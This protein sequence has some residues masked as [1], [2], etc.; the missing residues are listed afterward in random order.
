MSDLRRAARAAIFALAGAVS[1]G[2]CIAPAARP[3]SVEQLRHRLV[4]A[5]RARQAAQDTFDVLRRRRATDLPPDSL[6]SG[7]VRVRYA[8]ENLGPD[9][10]ATL[11]AAVRNAAIL[12]DRQF[13]DARFDAAQSVIVVNRVQR[14]QFAALTVDIVQVEL[15][16]PSGRMLTLR[17]PVTQR[18]LSDGILDML[19]SVATNGIPPNVSLW[20]GYRAPSQPLTGDDWQAAALDL[21]TSNSAV[22]RACYSGSIAGCESALGLVPARDPL[23]EWYTPE[24]WRALV[25]SVS[26]PINDAKQKAAYDECVD[27]KVFATCERLARQRQIPVPLNMSTRATLFDLAIA[28]GGRSAYA[29]LR[30]ATG[31][32]LEALSEVAGV[33]P[34]TLVDDW[35]TRAL[36]AV[37]HSIRP[38]AADSAVLVTWTL[39]FGI[40][41]TR[42]RPSS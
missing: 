33:P 30:T 34:A 41:A 5:L 35:R 26:P 32:P 42:R 38:S 24:G 12:A 13:G 27:K 39:L 14:M 36:A 8:E 10:E 7:V 31:T 29:R 1:A 4:S 20:A 25:G 2:V 9:L 3:Q 18:K 22:S 16:G 11:R 28:R 40:A 15:P 6:V 37:P 21:T 17:S 23:V 19:G